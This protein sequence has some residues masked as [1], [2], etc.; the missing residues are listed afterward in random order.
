MEM[1][2]NSS[3]FFFVSNRRWMKQASDMNYYRPRICWFAPNMSFMLMFVHVPCFNQT[4]QTSQQQQHQRKSDFMR[5]LSSP[6]RDSL[7]FSDL[8][9][10]VLASDTRFRL[11]PSVC[12]ESS[13]LV[14]MHYTSSRF[15]PLSL[16]FIIFFPSFQ[17][18][19]HCT[20]VLIFRFFLFVAFGV[21]LFTYSYI[22]LILAVCVSFFLLV[23]VLTY[24]WNIFFRFSRINNNF[25]NIG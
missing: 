6:L 21:W 25:I 22:C 7:S 8:L 9:L 12:L 4:N 2:R 23:G 13:T 20:L 17:L 5:G 14:S 3:F 24:L 15:S 10:V 1:A 11:F 18:H 16:L 19:S